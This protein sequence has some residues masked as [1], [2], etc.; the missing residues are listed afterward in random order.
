[1]EAQ[2][3]E[4][5]P[6]L[7][8]KNPQARHLALENLLPQTAQGAPYRDAIFLKGLGGGGLQKAKETD[9]IRDLKLLCRDQLNVAHDAFRALVN[10]SDSPAL[11][12][13]L[14][15][16]TFLNFIVSY[17]INPH[18][19][20]ADLASMLLSN[21]TAS[22]VPC[23]AI[24]NMK[25]S[26]IPYKSREDGSNL[27]YPVDSRSGSC[28]TPVPY[29]PG[30]P[31]EV[32]A[33]PLLIDAFVQGA[34]MG[35]ISDLS[36]RKRKGELNFLASVFANLTVSP[37]GRVLFL[38]AQPLHIVKP[39]GEPQPEKEVL[40]YPLAKIVPFTEHKDSIRRKGV[41]STIKNCCFLV[42]GHKAILTPETEQVAVKPSKVLAAGVDALPYILLPL[43]GPEEF[44]LDDQEKLLPAL[45]FLPPEKKRE[46]DA[47]IRLTLVEALL[48]LCHTRWGRDYQREH[49]V[50]EI[51]R[52]LH[53]QEKD[54]KV[55]EHIER[56]VVLLKSE[57]PKV[58]TADDEDEEE[59]VEM[60]LDQPAKKEE[61]DDED[62][63]I[64]EI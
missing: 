60:N 51:V 30:E 21:L 54:E 10:L 28:P 35:E 52:A 37:A 3:R 53:L 1:M 33:I 20:C 58:Q 13:P 62:L 14:S 45:Q 15:E 17:I 25:I 44:D 59:D 24:I 48:L 36:K 5:V 42:K 40:E 16:P 8:D 56:L 23:N 50:Y 22:S 46:S 41:A 27:V 2:L 4:L 47:L 63:I 19:I 61:S 57:E 34:T 7:R 31:K 6:F 64:E 55:A 9:I 12:G 29:P 18:S 49:G 39:D 38:K 43:A 26:V 11:V 32:A